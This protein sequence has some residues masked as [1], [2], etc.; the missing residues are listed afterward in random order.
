MNRAEASFLEY[1][2][3]EYYPSNSFTL[4]EMARPSAFTLTFGGD[5]HDLPIS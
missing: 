5:A 2:L 3:P 1:G 4:A